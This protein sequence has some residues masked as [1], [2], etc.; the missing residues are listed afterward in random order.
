[1]P[2][3]ASSFREA[4]RMASEVYHTLKTIIKK[5]YGQVC[6]ASKGYNLGCTR[7]CSREGP[8]TGPEGL[9]LLPS[10]KCSASYIY[11]PAPGLHVL[12]NATSVGAKG[13]ICALHQL[14]F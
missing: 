12:Q 1:M 2:V 9:C 8:C 10:A 13:G 14:C 5:K 6:L 7:N 11:M 3:G 4:L